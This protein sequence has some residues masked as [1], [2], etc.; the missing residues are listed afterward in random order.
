MT[1]VR[2]LMFR[3]SQPIHRLRLHQSLP[4]IIAVVLS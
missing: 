1:F 3:W 2:D 4:K